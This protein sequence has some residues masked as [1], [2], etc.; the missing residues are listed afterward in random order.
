MIAELVTSDARVASFLAT[1]D[2]E[3]RAAFSR[4]LEDSRFGG[5]LAWVYGSGFP[6]SRD[7]ARG[8]DGLDAGESRRARALR[9][10]EWMRSTGLTAA[11]INTLTGSTMGGHYLTS[12]SQP[13][14]ATRAH[15]EAMRPHIQGVIP[16]W[17]ERMV[18]ER[19]VESANLNRR[20]VIGHHGNANAMACFRANYIGDREPERGKITAPLTDEARAWE[21]WGTA[22]KPALEPCVLARK[23]LAEGTVAANVLAHGCGA[24]NIDGCRIRGEGAQDDS[25]TV[26]RFVPGLDTTGRW[27][28]DPT[29]HSEAK[30]GRWP[31]NVIHDGSAEAVAGFPDT[32][33][34]QIGGNN[35][36]NGSLGYHGGARGCT[37]PGVADTGS[38]ARY[39]YS[40][41]ADADDRLGFDHPTVKPIDLLRWLVRLVTPPGGAVLDPFAGTGTT[42]A[43]A[44]REG[45]SAVLVER[46]DAYCAM[47]GERLAF[48]TA[49]PATRAAA[50]GRRR[51]KRKGGDALPL[52]GE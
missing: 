20:E 52:F 37:A 38:A 48:E 6:K 13:A 4:C 47:I 23:P 27:T 34:G 14:V 5:M 45:A 18:D 43:A 36:P 50:R 26:R 30:L 3:Q 39:F 40:P 28:C 1:L 22:L 51:A 21:G 12:A 31:A 32:G 46:E 2:H 11:R 35:D 16:E 44:V 25:Q 33:R 41:K 10:T 17:V 19:S 42:A 24:F 8:I 15:L 9:F 49:G 29:D 7:V